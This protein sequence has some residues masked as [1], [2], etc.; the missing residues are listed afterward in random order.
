VSASD[1]LAR[2]FLLKTEVNAPGGNTYDLETPIERRYAHV[3]RIDTFVICPVRQ[4]RLT[5]MLNDLQRPEL[6]PD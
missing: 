2:F 4:Q 5:F 6:S 1:R 3:S